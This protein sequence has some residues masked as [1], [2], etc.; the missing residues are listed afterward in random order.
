[1]FSHGFPPLDRGGLYPSHGGILDPLSQSLPP[2]SHHNPL[3]HSA[4]LSSHHSRAVAGSS[5]VSPSPSISIPSELSSKDRSIHSVRDETKP[6]LLQDR[7][8]LYT[9]STIGTSSEPL[10]SPSSDPFRHRDINTTPQTPLGKNG[11][12]DIRRSSVKLIAN[13]TT[14]A[15][16][17]SSQIVSTVYKSHNHQDETSTMSVSSTS[18]SV[19]SSTTRDHAS[20]KSI[21]SHL[22]HSSSLVKTSTSMSLGKNQD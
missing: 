13:Q 10:R 3:Q 19:S 11:M 12:E 7:S 8:K 20:T 2:P 15:A 5:H 14:S 1:M 17:C 9:K 22:V 6:E 16:S 18:V 4:F 21:S